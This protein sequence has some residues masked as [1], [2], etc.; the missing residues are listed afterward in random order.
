MARTVGP[1][2]LTRRA[3]AGCLAALLLAPAS[4]RAACTWVDSV[5]GWNG[6]LAWSYAHQASWSNGSIDYDGQTQD[7]LSATFELDVSFLGQASGPMEGTMTYFGHLDVDSGI[8]EPGYLE[9]QGS[10]PFD[11]YAPPEPEVFLF[12][13]SF[14]CTYT[15][16]YGPGLGAEGTNTVKS[17]GATQTTAGIVEPGT[18][19]IPNFL[20]L[21]ET[22]QPLTFS[23][24]VDA[25]TLPP[26]PP[27]VDPFYS[28]PDFAYDSAEF[29]GE[30]Q[31]GKASAQ[32]A[33]QPE[34]FTQP[35]ND[36]CAGA[37]GLL[38]SAAV[39]DTTFATSASDPT[40]TCGAGD[41]SVW[42]LVQV[43]ASG[44]AS[45]ETSGS[46]YGTIVS[47]WPMAE[48]CGAI[49]TQ[50]AC[51]AG[52]ASWSA[53]PGTT[54]RVQVAR[55]SGVGGSLIAYAT[56][57]VPEPGWSAGWAAALTLAALWRTRRPRPSPARAGRRAPAE[58]P[59]SAAS[60]PARGSR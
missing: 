44:T 43:G 4:A 12:V 54:Y 41:R 35:L 57:P 10:G 33:F 55:G 27:I 21:P 18:L 34:G 14:A 38:G 22:P 28:V 42:F 8:G 3:G 20:P 7:Q 48:P 17:G 9:D 5:T 16:S 24:Q 45:V 53:T 31:L 59:R 19:M 25:V 23:G 58:R 60:Q 30:A 37:I 51:G 11:A 13:D 46:D 26:L 2:T 52:S 6:S 40:P 1:V 32:W 15:F 47:V 49:T 56:V 50:V 29:L 36:S 39:Q